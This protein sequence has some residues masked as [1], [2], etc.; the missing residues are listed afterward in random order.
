MI[1]IGPQPDVAPRSSE[2]KAKIDLWIKEISPSNELRKWFSHDPGEWED[3]KKRYERELNGKEGL[4]NEVKQIEKEKGTIT[5]FYSAKE[6]GHSNVVA[7]D[8]ILRRR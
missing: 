2:E 5:F 3:F 4:L 8:D 1:S 6:E 7:F